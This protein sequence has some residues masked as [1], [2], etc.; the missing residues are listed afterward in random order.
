MV[1]SSWH[2]YAA[3]V[4]Y[5]DAQIGLLLDELD[6]LELRDNTIVVM[7][8][9]HGFERGDLGMQC[10]HT[11]FELDT[12]VPLIVSAPKMA[13]D[14]SSGALVELV[15]WLFRAYDRLSLHA[16]AKEENS[17]KQQELAGG[18]LATRLAHQSWPVAGVSWL[19]QNAPVDTPD[20]EFR[21]D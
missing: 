4:S 8:S 18:Q 3:C 16:V 1:R 7:W 15:D 9:D 5:V 10:K 11:T 20:D 2:G 17:T 19:Q 12:R 14:A 13:K 6:R 21:L